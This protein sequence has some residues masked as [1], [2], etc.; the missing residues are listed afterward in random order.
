MMT[1]QELRE[2]K[3]AKRAAD[4]AKQEASRIFYKGWR[5]Q[6]AIG[7]TGGAPNIGVEAYR[8]GDGEHYFSK[9]E[10]MRRPGS[11]NGRNHQRT[12]GHDLQLAP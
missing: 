12:T 6:I 1:T 11:I 4:L 3:I 2:A 9:T 10:E 5:I 8:S 7:H